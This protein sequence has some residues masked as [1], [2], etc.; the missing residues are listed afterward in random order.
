[1]GD[2][3]TEKKTEGK[4]KRLANLRPPFPKGHKPTGHRQKGTRN[5]KTVAKELLRMKMLDFA[6]APSPEQT[7][8]EGMTAN[9]IR[10]AINKGGHDLGLVLDR[11]EGAVEQ[12]VN[13]EDELGGLTDAQREALEKLAVAR[14]TNNR[15]R[16]AKSVDGGGA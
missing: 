16:D 15:G 2:E 6:K 9:A 11:T 4:L 5:F 12:T 1:M 7:V 3:K 13:I 10:R 8:L 14:R